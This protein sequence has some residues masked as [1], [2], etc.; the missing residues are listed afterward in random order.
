[1][2]ECRLGAAPTG[3]AAPH[4]GFR[5]RPGGGPAGRWHTGHRRRRG[6]VVRRGHRGWPADRPILRRRACRRRARGGGRGGG[7]GGV[8]SGCGGGGGGGGGGGAVGGGFRES[9]GV[10][11]VLD[12]I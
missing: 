8:A 9:D 3:V 7:G 5:A 2:R 1:M 10:T 6:P 4:R 11:R 12:T